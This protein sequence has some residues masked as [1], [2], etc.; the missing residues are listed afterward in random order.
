MNCETVERD[1]IIE[2]Y[3]AGTL[4]PELRDEWE[5]HYFA[6]DACMEKL[7]TWQAIERPLRGMERE[8]RAEPVRRPSRK[9]VWLPIG[10]AAAVVAAVLGA[11]LAP[12]SKS[13]PPP[14]AT[15]ER[16]RASIAELAQV[17]PPAYRMPVERGIQTE[18]ERQ[19]HAA[20]RKYTAGDY[21]GAIPG[22]RTAIEADRSNDAARFFL[23]A[24]EL[25]SGDNAAATE[26]LKAVAGGSSPF[27][28]EAR[29][30]LS[31]AYLKANRREDALA[32][33]AKIA[34]AGG[35]FERQAVEQMTRIKIAP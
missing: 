17:T 6:C 23:G 20:M 13:V 32:E 7:E 16:P 25:L 26:D 9:V 14:V 27:A 33:L 19:F 12:T 28:E 10:I 29:W 11:R 8:I 34:A 30:N 4:P 31:Q 5:Q 18:S 3:L 15:T 35:D 21:A 2:R 22:L 1:N 24:C